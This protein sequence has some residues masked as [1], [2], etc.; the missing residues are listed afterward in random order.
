MHLVQMGHQCYLMGCNLSLYV[1]CAEKWVVL[2]M[3][4]QFD[5]GFNDAIYS[6]LWCTVSQCVTWAFSTSP[7]PPAIA[8]SPQRKTILSKLPLLKSLNGHVARYRPIQ[9]VRLFRHG[10][11]V[12]YYKSKCGVDGAAEFRASLRFPTSR[13]DWESKVVT[14]TLKTLIVNHIPGVQVCSSG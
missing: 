5:D 7:S 6:A 4:V 12:F 9:P 3:L 2:T 10:L 1:C 13:F 11:R 8:T 14:Q